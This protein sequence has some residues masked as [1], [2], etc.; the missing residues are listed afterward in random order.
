MA[1]KTSVTSVSLKPETWTRLALYK[2][3]VVASQ[4][5]PDPS[6]DDAVNHLLDSA[7]F[8]RGPKEGKK[9]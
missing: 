2:G 6:F 9:E 5:L 3:K 8:P 1:R 7:G 4:E